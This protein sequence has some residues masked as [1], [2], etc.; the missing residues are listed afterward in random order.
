MEI[1][2]AEIKLVLFLILKSLKTKI[3]NYSSLKN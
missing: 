2:Q 3:N 1:F